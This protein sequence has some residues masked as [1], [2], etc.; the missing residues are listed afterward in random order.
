MTIRR[1]PTAL[2][3]LALILMEVAAV[4][5][6]ICGVF[7]WGAL[8]PSYPS[9]LDYANFVKHTILPIFWSLDLVAV[10]TPII[11]YH[12]IFSVAYLTLYVL[13]LWICVAASGA[14]VYPVFDWDTWKGVPYY[15]YV[16]ALLLGSQF[17]VGLLA[18]ARERVNK[19]GRECN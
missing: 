7:Y 12:F 19:D 3:K 15:F 11:S 9:T 17:L 8:Y 14:W 18:F 16:V 5:S 1:K 13:F 4:A 2:Q 10:R 6:I